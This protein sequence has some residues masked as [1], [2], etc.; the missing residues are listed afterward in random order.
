MKIKA[1]THDD[2][3]EVVLELILGLLH[4]AERVLLHMRAHLSH[5][6]T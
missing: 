2:F 5:S 3:L 1:K 6:L 4:E